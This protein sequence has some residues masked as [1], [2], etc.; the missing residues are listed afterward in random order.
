MQAVAVM[1]AVLTMLGSVPAGRTAPSAGWEE[2]AAQV[3]EAE[4]EEAGRRPL[5]Q[6]AGFQ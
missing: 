3:L 6:R 5:R 4:P 1:L 2:V